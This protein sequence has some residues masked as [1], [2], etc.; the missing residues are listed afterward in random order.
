MFNPFG[1]GSARQGFGQQGSNQPYDFKGL[2][3]RLGK[4]ETGIAGLT[5]QFGNFKMPGQETVD[6]EYTGNAAPDPLT[7][8]TPTG[9]IQSLPAAEPTQPT[10]SGGGQALRQMMVD[11]ST[12]W[13]GA[14][15][16]PLTE[17]QFNTQSGQW[18][19]HLDY[20]DFSDMAAGMTGVGDAGRRK[21]GADPRFMHAY[22]AWQGADQSQGMENWM[23]DYNF[24]LA[25]ERPEWQPNVDWQTSMANQQAYLDS[26]EYTDWQQRQEALGPVSAAT[27]SAMMGGR[28]GGTLGLNSISPYIRN[29]GLFNQG[30]FG[31]PGETPTYE[32]YLSDIQTSQQQSQELANLKPQI[33]GQPQQGLQ[34][35]LGA[36]IG[37]LTGPTQQ[38]IQG[39]MT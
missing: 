7:T 36:G 27:Q 29:E 20:R 32:N 1:M 23:Q 34:Q 30:I 17:E 5:E 2:E 39:Y 24:D 12:T 31:R 4:I 13:G 18:G 11:P 35:G 15:Y 14:N 6:P 8:A 33:P 25:P 26:P 28:H 19:E 9:G 3:S 22:D 10:Q 16:T 38:K 21:M 37:A